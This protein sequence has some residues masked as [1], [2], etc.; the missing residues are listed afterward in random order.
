M[1][2]FDFNPIYLVWLFVAVSA[3]LVFEAIYLT[4][5]SASSYRSR[6]NR[7]LMIA[8]DRT[9]R[10]SVLI[11]LRRERGLTAGGDYR[12]SLVALNRLVLQSGITIGFTRLLIVIAV[13]SVAAFGVT[14]MVRGNILEAAV[15][16]L[17]CAT[18]LP[19]MVLRVLRSRR[20]KRFGAQFPDA[21][22]IIV[23]SLRAGHPVPIA[24]S[25]V[26][27]EMPDP[28]GSEFGIVSDETTFGADLETAMR[29]LYG[30]LGSDDLPLFVTA[31][32]IQSSTGGNLGEILENLSGVIRQRFKMRRK[33]RALAAEG[34]ASAMILSAL[35]IGMFLVI[36]LIAPDFYGSVWQEH[37]TKLLLLCAGGWMCVGNLIMF[38]MV[39]F[40]I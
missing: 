15:A 17:V 38:K 36:Q 37:L 14:M 11:E 39:N 20:Q 32:A 4:C 29:N 5:Y 35:P 1:L 34:R 13:V 25:M 16:A 8:K 18:V 40:K 7:R 27:R 2:S 30:R 21:L 12:L 31:V 26:G 23:R 22:D 3:G 33:I 10:E 6:I 28:I 24:I 9:D 19:Y